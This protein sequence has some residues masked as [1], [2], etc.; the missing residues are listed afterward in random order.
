MSNKLPTR[1]F[2]FSLFVIFLDPKKRGT[3]R[4]D[5][6]PVPSHDEIPIHSHT[7]SLVMSYRSVHECWSS[8]PAEHW[9]R[10]GM[11][12]NELL[13]SAAI[14]MQSEPAGKK[15]DI[16]RNR[17]LF[18]SG[19]DHEST[20]KQIIPALRGKKIGGRRGRCQQNGNGQQNEKVNRNEQV[21]K[22]ITGK[23]GATYSAWGCVSRKKR[24]SNE[25]KL[26]YVLIT[27]P[28]W[29]TSSWNLSNAMSSIC[30]MNMSTWT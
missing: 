24:E 2:H 8:R 10:C 27:W 7:L 19:R 12:P 30:C 25:W 17:L 4:W 14:D 28:L 18:D 16:G 3:D 1:F 26:R 23:K 20:K 15:A 29:V 9:I 5:P 13:I 6:C 21:N 22:S 11:Q